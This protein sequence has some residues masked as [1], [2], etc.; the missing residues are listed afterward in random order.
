M[1]HASRVHWS[2]GQ[3]ETE[4]LPP[5]CHPDAPPHGGLEC[6]PTC[7]RSH[8]IGR[9]RA[10]RYPDFSPKKTIKSAKLIK[11][12]EEFHQFWGLRGPDSDFIFINVNV[13]NNIEPASCLVSSREA[14]VFFPVNLKR[15]RFDMSI[16]S[17]KHSSKIGTFVA[18]LVLSI[19]LGAS[20]A[21]A[22]E[23]V[24]HEV[25]V[26]DLSGSSEGEP[27][28]LVIYGMGF[29]DSTAVYLGTQM[30]PLAI[31][32]DQSL[33]ATLSG[34]PLDDTD[35]ECVVAELP[36][37]IPDGD[38]LLYIEASE[39]DAAEGGGLDSKTYSTW[40]CRYNMTISWLKKGDT[41]D[42]GPQGKIGPTGDQ[43]P[44]G[45]I[46]PT[47]DQGPQ[48]KIGP[49]GAQGPQGKI[50]RPATRDRRARS[51]R[52]AR[53]DRRARSARPARR[54]RRVK[55]APKARR[56]TR[57]RRARS[58]RPARRD[59]RVKSARPARRDRRV[60]SAPKARRATRDR[61]V[62]SAPK[63]RRVSPV[64]VARRDRKVKSAPKA[65]RAT[66]D[67]RARSARPARRDRRAS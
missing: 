19:F 63:A 60:K 46:G 2:G 33:C 64:K 40:S 22:Q 39:G 53:R 28:L 43:G 4:S 6:L 27:E 26:V 34:V 36:D 54:D 30:T 41:G 7:P 44:Q 10:R 49:S 58:A 47:G 25:Q 14:S 62:K 52:P 42:Q 32:E 65:R 67:R 55:S 38:Y 16:H 50:G 8:R 13:S 11:Y 37:V 20:P 59:R 48:G 23:G 17:S 61:R 5:T 35:I 57:D 29:G 24:V 51:A 3:V 15:G 66:R 31:P 45:K 12:D 56:A 18:V 21:F 9:A 1:V